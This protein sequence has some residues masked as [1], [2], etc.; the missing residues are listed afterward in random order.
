MLQREFQSISMHIQKIKV[1][2]FCNFA[3]FLKIL[4]FPLLIMQLMSPQ[5]MAVV[6][7]EILKGV[8]LLYRDISCKDL[9]KC[10]NNKNEKIIIENAVEFQNQIKNLIEKSQ[11]QPFVLNSRNSWAP[12]DIELDSLVQRENGHVA[13][14]IRGRIFFPRSY[15]SC[16]TNNWPVTVIVNKLSDNF[17]SELKIAEEIANQDRGIALF[18]YLPH[19]GPRKGAENFITKNVDEFEKNIIQ[20]VVDL[21]V[22]NQYLKTVPGVDKNNIGLMGLSLGGMITLIAAGLDPVYNRYGTNV[23]GGDL[24]NIITYRKTGDVDSQTGQALKD[25]D[26][27]VDEAR[28][29]FSRFD[30]VTWSYNVKN[31]RILM[32]NA[33]K[34]ELI[35]KSLSVDNLIEGYK[36][37]G[38]QVQLVMHKGS[39][40]Y[41]FREV[42]VFES[43]FKVFMPMLQFAGEPNQN[44]RL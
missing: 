42:G 39:H 11:V 6:P 18:L 24:A 5:A 35:N 20:S 26:W 7:E 41:R 16:S 38:S 23:A 2:I 30:A 40:V 28:L 33:N 29:R 21:H 36:G 8:Q 34:D 32:I 25:I 9:E 44:C 10:L 27:S 19:F 3:N 31:K 15:A 43:L 22:V 1:K 14:K 37:A 12:T 17:D 4:S 13:N